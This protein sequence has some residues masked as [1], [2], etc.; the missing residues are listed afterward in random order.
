MLLNFIPMQLK[1][2]ITKYLFV[3][4]VALLLI[5]VAIDFIKKNSSKK[6]K[7]NTELTANYIDSVFISVLAEYGIEDQWISV[8]NIS[9]PYEDS[10]SRQLIIKLPADLSIPLIIKDVNRIIENDITGFVSEEKK[11]FGTTEIRIYSNEILKFQASLIPDANTIRDRNKLSIIIS[12]AYDLSA[13]DFNSFISIPHNLCAATIPGQNTEAQADSLKTYSKEFIVIL[14]DENTE[15]KFRLDPGD[16]K[17]LLKNSVINILSGFKNAV[18]FCVDEQCKLFNSTVYNY[19]RDDFK[20]HG[21]KLVHKAEF[22]QISSDDETELF[23]KFKYHAEDKSG[24]NQKIFLMTFEEFLKIRN[25]LE[26]F[27]K[28]GH[29]IIPLSRTDFKKSIS[30]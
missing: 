25:E 9:L 17:E 20:R 4:A 15:T 28:K 10:I 29:T 7:P 11:I 8:K 12:D 2:Q 21:V 16:R 26:K 23:S 3:I 22:I 30:N 13:S 27:R 19:V 14:N 5:N 1:K 18:L 24:G 6:E